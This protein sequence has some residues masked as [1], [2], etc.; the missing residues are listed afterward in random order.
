[1]GQFIVRLQCPDQPGIVHSVSEAL[2]RAG[3]NITE[4]AQF[5]DPVTGDFCMRLQVSID[6]EAEEIHR[7]VA[8]QVERFNPVV[9]V[10]PLE[11]RPRTAIMVS[12]FDHCL[13][14]L[15]YRWEIDELAVDIP[16]VISNHKDVRPLVERH[17]IP[18]VYIPV[19]PET[20]AQAE[21][22]LFELIEEYSIDV[23]V[24]ARYMQILSDD[25]CRRLAGRAI[26]IHHSFLP[27]FKGA[28][29]YHQA[30]ARGVKLIG[31]TAHYVTADLDE[32]PII[33]QE[34]VRVHHT[35]SAEEFVRIGRDIE[36]VVLARALRLHAQ[37]R[38]F[39][40]GARTV[41]FGE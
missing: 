13:V 15:L 26:N 6:L 20:K 1:M 14:D 18:F 9:A 41:V 4:N 29:P 37:K 36:R 23:V 28:K 34:V 32:G 35:Q 25:A 40:T 12:T 19:T 31:A 30:Y 16:V 22:R 8:S 2:L 3:G 24:L 7:Q 27:G 38:V 5:S 33:E 39:L 21:E 10:A 11:Y 17:G